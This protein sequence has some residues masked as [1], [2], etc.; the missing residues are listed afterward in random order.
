MSLVSCK[1]SKKLSSINP[2]STKKKTSIVLKIRNNRA[3]IAIINKTNLELFYH[4]LTLQQPWW[5]F[6]VLIKM[7]CLNFWISERNSF[8]IWKCFWLSSSWFHVCYSI[9]SHICCFIAGTSQ[10]GLLTSVEDSIFATICQDC[11]ENAW[12]KAE[13]ILVAAGN[14]PP[15]TSV[16]SMSNPPCY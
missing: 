4:T 9:F 5:M 6:A 1:G 15:V 2:K 8:Q 13:I 16:L 10:E 3:Q 11:P 12:R 7:L 14:L